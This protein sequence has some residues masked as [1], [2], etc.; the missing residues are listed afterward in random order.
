MFPTFIKKKGQ[1][2]DGFYLTHKFKKY[3]GEDWNKNGIHGEMLAE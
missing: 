2:I 1:P 3:L